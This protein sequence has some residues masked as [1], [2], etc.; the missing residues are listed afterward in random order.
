M[1]LTGL[2]LEKNMHDM[3]KSQKYHHIINVLQYMY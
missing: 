2:H 1:I 3:K